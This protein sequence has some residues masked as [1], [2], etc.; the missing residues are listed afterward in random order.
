M[1]RKVGEMGGTGGMWAL[2]AG[3]DPGVDPESG[4]EVNVDLGVERKA[5]EGDS[6]CGDRK[7]G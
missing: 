7:S 1:K 5:R 6:G 4:G 3:V 2:W